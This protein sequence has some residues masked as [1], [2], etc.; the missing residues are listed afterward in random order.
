MLEPRELSDKAILNSLRSNGMQ[1]A[2]VDKFGMEKG[3]N[4][5]PIQFLER[6]RSNY[7]A[8]Y[9]G[10]KAEELRQARAI[11][12]RNREKD[13]GPEPTPLHVEPVIQEAQAGLEALL[14]NQELALTKEYARRQARIKE[15]E[16]QL[17]L[18][19]ASFEKTMSELD[20]VRRFI[21]ELNSGN[22]KPTVPSKMGEDISREVGLGES[23]SG[24][25]VGA[26]GRTRKRKQGGAEPDPDNSR[27]A[28]EESAAPKGELALFESLVE[29]NE[30]VAG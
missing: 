16:N 2:F 20:T 8:W 17:H 1:K 10:Q 12:D 15:L 22:D 18:E 3:K 26:K 14:L 11:A 23:D 6:F 13:K 29:V 28:G 25:G 7:S 4:E 27:G 19:Y 24:Q 5:R 21:K 30:P 9:D